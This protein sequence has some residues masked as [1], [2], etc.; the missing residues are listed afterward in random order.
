[1]D[2]KGTSVNCT[3][4]RGDEESASMVRQAAIEIQR[5]T[6][7]GILLST[8]A[9]HDFE[10]AVLEAAEDR[11]PAE[12]DA[13]L[14]LAGAGAEQTRL[15]LAWAAASLVDAEQVIQLALRTRRPHV[16]R[17]VCTRL[18]ESA[19]DDEHWGAWQ[20]L[21]WIAPTQL[22][23]MVK[24]HPR[25]SGLCREAEDAMRQRDRARRARRARRSRAEGGQ[26]NAAAGQCHAQGL[27]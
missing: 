20:L 6:P 2:Q 4:D 5:S 12:E 21:S 23:A 7:L 1:M 27:I 15:A 22:R 14:T 3:R 25:I 18:A 16:A 11:C 8:V 13:W 26:V 17:A 9:A 24:A 10:A 19:H